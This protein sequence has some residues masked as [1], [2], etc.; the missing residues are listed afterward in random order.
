MPPWSLLVTSLKI[1]PIF[2]ISREPS[3]AQSFERS[4]DFG[5]CTY[6][7]LSVVTRALPFIRTT[8]SRSPPLTLMKYGRFRGYCE[9]DPSDHCR[10]NPALIVF[11]VFNPDYWTIIPTRAYIGPIP[12]NS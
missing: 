2:G 6:T 5:Q 4:N 3:L 11:F 9:R 8:S 7:S 10:A 1:Y 12:A